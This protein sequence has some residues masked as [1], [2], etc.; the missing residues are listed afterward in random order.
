MTYL[1][2]MIEPIP[3]AS[4]LASLAKLLPRGQWNRIRHLIYCKAHYRC[5]VCARKGRLHCHEVWQFNH[6][7]GYQHLRGFQALCQDC[8]QVKHIFFVHDAQRRASLLRHLGVVN[9]LTPIQVEEQIIAARSRQATLD[10]L[11]WIVNY[12][13]YNW[14]VHSARG[15]QQRKAFARFNGQQRRHCSP[16]PDHIST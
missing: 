6:R 16:I 4:R 5:H 2:L 12:G 3:S 7:T 9:R 13:P 11:H 1:R 8:H 14:H 15:I 10:G